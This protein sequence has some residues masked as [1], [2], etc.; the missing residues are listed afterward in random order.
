MRPT[1]RAYQADAWRRRNKPDARALRPGAGMALRAAGGARWRCAS[2]ARRICGAA[3]AASSAASGGAA[4]EASGAASQ[5]PGGAGR[6][7]RREAARAGRRAF[8]QQAVG[9]IRSVCAAV[10][11]VAQR[12]CRSG[13]QAGGAG[14]WCGAPS[15]RHLLRAP[16]PTAKVYPLKGV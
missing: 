6:A 11:L 5:Q 9:Q 12:A 16:R 7:G 10:E 14:A 1:G 3:G 4:G 8:V 2:S 13:T 15:Y